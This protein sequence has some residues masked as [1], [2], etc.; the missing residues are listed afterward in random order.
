MIK[1]F[2]FLLAFLYLL[3]YILAKIKKQRR[4]IYYDYAKVWNGCT[5]DLSQM[6]M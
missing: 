1:K 2:M 6:W 3:C 4:K 5:G